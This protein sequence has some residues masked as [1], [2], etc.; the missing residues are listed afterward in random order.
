VTLCF[1]ISGLVASGGCGEI[2]QI[3]APSSFKTPVTCCKA[4]SS[5]LQ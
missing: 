1:S 3:V 4:Y 2:A 5:A